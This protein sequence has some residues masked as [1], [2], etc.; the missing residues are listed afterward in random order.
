MTTPPNDGAE[1][2]DPTAEPVSLDKPAAEQ[3]FD[4]YR[5]GAP[6]HP[7]PPEYAPPGYV[8]PP[9]AEPPPP[10]MPPAYPGYGT[11][12]YPTQ[13]YAGQPYPG[14][15]GQPYPY[16]P[17]YYGQYPPPPTGNGKAIA[18]LVLGIAAILLFWTSILDIVPAVLALVF[19]ILGRNE[20][21]R[22]GQGRRLAVAGIACAV[23]G[24]L[25]ATVFTVVI[26]Q[27]IKPCLD[28]Y[29]QGSTAQEDCIRDRLP[30]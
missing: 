22:H 25:L 18:A 20:A 5:F 23:V 19:G 29:A 30:H 1:P 2:S 7:V 17:N 4:P 28:N 21:K 6:E 15:P 14:Q 13:Q 9:A 11:P 27:R 8:P 26:F 24:A 12:P 10:S 16:P 3:P